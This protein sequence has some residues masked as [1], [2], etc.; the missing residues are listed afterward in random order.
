M[1][2]PIRHD[3]DQLEDDYRLAFTRNDEYALQRLKSAI[4]TMRY[5]LR[6]DNTIQLEYPNHDEPLV[7]RIIQNEKD[8][9]RWIDQRF[10]R[11]T[12]LS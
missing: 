6:M 11:L 1:S 10:I 5:E 9:D 4:A 8:F 7:M 3:L 2:T 12:E